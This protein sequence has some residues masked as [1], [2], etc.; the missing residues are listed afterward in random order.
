MQQGVYQSETGRA[1]H[2]LGF[3]F[4]SISPSETADSRLPNIA[5]Y[6]SPAAGYTLILTDWHLSR[7]WKQ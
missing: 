1:H 2:V 7:Y 4:V 3:W 6:S 5:A